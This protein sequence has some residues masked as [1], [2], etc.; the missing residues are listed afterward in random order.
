[1]ERCPPHTLRSDPQRSGNPNPLERT[2]DNPRAGLRGLDIRAAST[3]EGRR[4]MRG[5]KA[6][7]G[8]AQND[9][10][11][12]SDDRA[13]VWRSIVCD[14]GAKR[15]ELLAEQGIDLVGMS[16]SISKS[17]V[18]ATYSF[19]GSK[20]RVAITKKPFL[21]SEKFCEQRLREWLATN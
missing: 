11:P 5:D 2:A 17:G 15:D 4:R 16:G 19:D 20:L 1:M 3:I 10:G 14:A 18:S 21:V 9:G 7:D 12:G 13:Q 6:A 8:M